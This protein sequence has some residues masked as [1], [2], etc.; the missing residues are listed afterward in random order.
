MNLK[1]HKVKVDGN[2][3]V[4]T[5]KEYELLKHLM[6]NQNTVLTRNRLLEEV[7]GYDFAGESRTLD[8][9]IRSLRQKLGTA[10]DLIETVRGVGYRMG[11]IYEE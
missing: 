7:W 3:V 10:G 2:E 1:K 9:H 5:L 11:G 4:L 6:Q 8:V